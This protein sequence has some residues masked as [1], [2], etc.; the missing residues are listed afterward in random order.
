M[1]SIT[2]KVYKRPR[3]VLD[4]SNAATAFAI[5]YVRVFLY[6]VILK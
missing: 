5:M 3:N 1:I 4:H 2:L 6:V